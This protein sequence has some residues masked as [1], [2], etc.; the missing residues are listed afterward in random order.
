MLR[1]TFSTEGYKTSNDAVDDVTGL[2]VVIEV[3][4]REGPM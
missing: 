3:K 4:P 2:S 1:S